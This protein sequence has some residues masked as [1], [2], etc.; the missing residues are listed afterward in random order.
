MSQNEKTFF[1]V[2]LLTLGVLAFQ[3]CGQG[4]QSSNLQSATSSTIDGPDGRGATLPS[5]LGTTPDLTGLA[6]SLGQILGLAVTNFPGLST[7]AACESISPCTGAGPSTQTITA[8]CSVAG[9]TVTGSTSVSFNSSQCSPFNSSE[10]AIIP[11]LN[12]ALSGQSFV[13]SSAASTDYNGS[14]SAGGLFASYSLLNGSANLSDL[15]LHI[16]GSGAHPLDISTHSLSPSTATVNITAG[17]ISLSGG[18]IVLADNL[19][20][21]SAT[22]TPNNL[23]FGA[24]CACPTS[25]SISGPL[26][27]TTTGTLTMTF[28]ATCGAIT[29]SAPGVNTTQTVAGCVPL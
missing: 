3:A 26:S 24:G 20:H 22:L 12:I 9:E 7:L 23:G 28:S 10:I 13:V 16:T 6:L 25:G 4:F 1:K 5:G 17:Q 11:S 27:G 14:L 18:Q 21:Y 15:G 2:A 29:I 8:N 19:Q